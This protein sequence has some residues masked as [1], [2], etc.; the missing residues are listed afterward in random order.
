MVKWEV[1]RR[2]SRNTNSQLVS[3][4]KVQ[5]QRLLQSQSGEGNSSHCL[6]ELYSSLAVWKQPGDGGNLRE[7][8]CLSVSLREEQHQVDVGEKSRLTCPCNA[9]H[10]DCLATQMKLLRGCWVFSEAAFRGSGPASVLGFHRRGDQPFQWSRQVAG[11]LAD[12]PVN[13]YCNP[14][15]RR[16]FPTDRCSQK[17][18]NK[19]WLTSTIKLFLSKHSFIPSRHKA[20]AQKTKNMLF[21]EVV[22]A[23]L[24]V[25]VFHGYS[26]P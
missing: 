24:I 17:T 18:L 8:I 13:A 1:E 11:S 12:S 19:K 3:S 6:H 10:L 5:G 4:Q 14:D 2:Q 25:F 16:K 15:I 23:N 22:P 21:L 26:S 7:Y 9:Q 20:K